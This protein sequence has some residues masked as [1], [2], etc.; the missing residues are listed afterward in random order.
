MKKIFLILI[1]SAIFFASCD[2]K[3]DASII[4][5][6]TNAAFAPFEFIPAS[7]EG[8]HGQ[9]SGIDIAIG[10]RIAESLG[11]ELRI[12]DADFDGLLTDLNAGT[13]D[14]VAAA[15]SVNPG[16][17]EEAAF[18]V[19]YFTDVQFI[20]VSA[21][22]TEINGANDLHGLHIG[23]Q[24]GT[25]GEM[26]VLEN[27]EFS[28]LESYTLI[29]QSVVHLLSGGI[30]AI[31]VDSIYANRLVNQYAGLRLVSDEN[32]FEREDFGI[33]VRHEDTELLASINAV[34]TEMLEN[35]EIDALY[36]YYSEGAGE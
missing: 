30:D 18:S 25:T 27:I 20:V 5:M 17:L 19:P 4:V 28:E 13:V 11:A 32:A 15:M 34:L 12:L 33:A 36:V 6:G 22:N 24:T 9:Y 26:F 1:F 3:N 10:M 16:R 7:G 2:K 8:R 21:D 29:S 14:F 23:V 31:V 35:G